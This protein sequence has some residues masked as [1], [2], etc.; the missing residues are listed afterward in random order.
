MTTLIFLFVLLLLLSAFFSASETAIFSL[1]RVQIKK[2][3]ESK[4]W[5]I[6]KVGEYL[7]EPR[8][9]LATILLGNELMN[10]S[11]SIV[12]ATLIS[13]FFPSSAKTG[14]LLSILII[15]PIL[16]LLGEVIPKNI[17]LRLSDTIAPIMVIPLRVF[18]YCVTPFRI[19]LTSIADTF[20][21][22]FGGD[23]NASAA[24]VKEEEFRSLIDLGR[25]EG[26]LEEEEREIIHNVF[27]F[28]DELVKNII[29]PRDQIFMLPLD[30]E[31]KIMLEEIRAT[32]YRRIPI[33]EG[34]QTNI[35]GILHVRDL[36]SF[37]RKRKEN[38]NVSLK[39]I[40]HTPLFVRSN[41]KVEDL[42]KRIQQDRMHMALVLNKQQSLV[43]LATLHDVLERLFGEIEDE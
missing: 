39:S 26:L 21:K 31:Y 24:M 41:E 29:T 37:H 10:V 19:V 1:S 14:T 32:E 17:A 18:H 12:G 27:E 4:I 3:Q 35:I 38:S 36:F 6:K 34:E 25:D 28:T 43:G 2:F 15:T 23:P 7:D 30:M 9:F 5:V 13:H 22:C 33:Y 20:I 16:L 11:I 40:L 42:L 8:H